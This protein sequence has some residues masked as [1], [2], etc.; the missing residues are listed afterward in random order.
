MRALFTYLREHP[1]VW[2]VPIVLFVGGLGL[3]AWKIG[4]TPTS[5][6]VYDL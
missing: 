1:L 4:R 6:Y 5:P 2:I 3:L